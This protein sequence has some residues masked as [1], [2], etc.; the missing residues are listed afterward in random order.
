MNNDAFFQ[1][2]IPA[3]LERYELKYMVPISLVEPISEFVSAYCSLDKY[4][5]LSDDSFYEVNSLYFD[6]SEFTF[7]KNRILKVENRFNMRI[8]SYG[9][10]KKPPYFWEI[11]QKKGDISRK[12]RVNIGDCLDILYSH[13]HFKEMDFK[14][15]DKKNADLFIQLHDSYD[16]SPKVLT[17]Y[18]RKAYISDI[19]LYARVTFDKELCYTQAD[20]LNL[21]PPRDKMLYYDNQDIFALGCNVVLELK[22]LKGYV[23]QWMLDLIKKFDLERVGFSK[24]TNSLMDLFETSGNNPLE[25]LL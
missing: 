5:E 22:C 12:Y 13:S 24:Y 19:D 2:A 8:R 16:A 11:K 6:T 9:T 23:P 1:K 17:S 20:G 3:I 25:S 15:D 21:I 10:G 18:R 14:G 7:L 4:S